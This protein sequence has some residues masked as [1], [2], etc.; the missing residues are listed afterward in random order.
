[1]KNETNYKSLVTKCR[2]IM[3]TD[4]T[5]FFS[6]KKQLVVI[7]IE[8]QQMILYT[9]LYNVRSRRKKEI[10]EI[11][12]EIVSVAKSVEAKTPFYVGVI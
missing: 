5:L 2:Y 12:T 11:R 7:Y 4:Q 3:R 1:M 9:I 8:L 6:H 10:R